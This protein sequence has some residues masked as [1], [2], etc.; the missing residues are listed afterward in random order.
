MRIASGSM[1]GSVERPG[2][3]PVQ[4]ADQ[5]AQHRVGDEA[6]AVHLDDGR[7]VS[8]ERD[9]RSGLVSSH[10]RGHG[11]ALQ[12]HGT[13]STV[14]D[15]PLR[16]TKRR[17]R[18]AAAGRRRDRRARRTWN[19]S[20]APSGPAAAADG[21]PRGTRRD[22]PQG[23]IPDGGRRIPPSAQWVASP[24]SF[25]DEAKNGGTMATIQ[26]QIEVA[27][28][29]ALVRLHLEP[30]H[31]VGAHRPRTPPL[32]RTR[33]RR[34][35]ALGARR[36]RAH[37][38]RPD[39]RHLPHGRGAGRPAAGGDRAPARARPRGVQGLRRAQRP[40]R[41]QADRDGRDGGSRSSRTARAISRGTRG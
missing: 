21:P 25:S 24:T 2:H 15:R 23:P 31:P 18:R 26:Q 20:A 11:L 6:H 40:R 19:R 27:A 14:A 33:L 13:H 7:R 32:R 38:Q 41:S 29:P 4:R 28:D 34:R 35:G 5:P 8:Q 30:V 9:P 16:Q 39:D 10:P 22:S 36:L 37:D 17:G 3:A 12:I 1:S